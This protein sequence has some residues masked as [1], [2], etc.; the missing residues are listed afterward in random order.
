[1]VDHRA[2]TRLD[3]HARLRLPLVHDDGAI[4]SVVA[5]IVTS[6]AAVAA[7][8]AAIRPTVVS[9]IV[10]PIVAAVVA[11]DLDPRAL[12][13]DGGARDQGDAREREHEER[14]KDGHGSN[15]RAE[16]RQ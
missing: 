5:S 11:T 12:R 13:F 3:D 8:V 14:S 4:A 2:L 9:A 15:D 10:A 6:V 7:V 16:T 1:M